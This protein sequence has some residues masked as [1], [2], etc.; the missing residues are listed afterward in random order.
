M[1]IMG[2]PDLL[3]AWEL[4]KVLYSFLITK[5]GARMSEKIH[6]NTDSYKSC[7]ENDAPP[8]YRKVLL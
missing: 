4:E 1:L 8:Q 2:F 5:H 3:H 7:I 6:N